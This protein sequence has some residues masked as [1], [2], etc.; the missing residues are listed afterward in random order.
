MSSRFSTEQSLA[1]KIK[2]EAS[3]LGFYRCGVAEAA[4]VGGKT[5]GEFARWIASGCHA[6]MDYMAHNT[7]KRLD[8]ALLMPGVRSIVC[9][10]MAYAPPRTMPEGEYQIAAYALGRDYHDVMK[11]RL[12]SLA[13][14]MERL[15]AEAEAG[16][17]ASG[18]PALAMRV[19]CDTAPV[20]ERYWAWRA[21]LGWPGRNRQLIIPGAGS[22]FFLGEVF[23]NRSLPADS[24][25]EPRCG[26][27]RACIDAC[28]TSAIADGGPL[29]ARR[30][31]S[32][33]TIEHRGP[34][35]A[36]VE[37]V[38]GNSIYGCDRCQTACPWNRLAPVATD[39]ELQPNAA[40]LAMTKAGWHNLS[41]DDYRRLFKGS[42]VKR[43]K[44]EGLMRN[45]R[46][47]EACGAG[48]KGQE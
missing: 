24:P 43:A 16:K 2:A 22:M 10:A 8:P 34:L 5:A 1:D 23:V 11:A 17:A 39:P 40:L 28:P 13:A 46:A 3:R 30:C 35:P 32:Y 26:T 14:A 36:G 41:A 18:L 25:Q 4:P 29:D 19:F 12:R 38:V 6:G 21:G 45:I 33:L 27:C 44:Y 42:A 20:L 15:F 48:E 47:A 7:D 9:V 31:L 37:N